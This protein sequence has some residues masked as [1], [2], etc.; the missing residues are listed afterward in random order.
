MNPVIHFRSW[1]A[2]LRKM[3]NYLE[4]TTNTTNVKYYQYLNTPP[5][6]ASSR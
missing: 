6:D 5:P 3:R 1:R 2:V 4:N